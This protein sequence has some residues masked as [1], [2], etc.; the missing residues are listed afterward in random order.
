[1]KNLAISNLKKTN[2]AELEVKEPTGEPKPI[3]EGVQV[4]QK[5]LKCSML[6]SPSH[7]VTP[8]PARFDRGSHE[9]FY[10][11]FPGISKV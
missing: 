10:P 6:L 5:S 8:P 9:S 11:L 1:M 2:A 3:K 7:V 4:G